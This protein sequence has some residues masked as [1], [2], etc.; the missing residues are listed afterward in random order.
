[1]Y[2]EHF[3]FRPAAILPVNKKC[4][5]VTRWCPV[6]FALRPN[7]ADPIIQ[8]PYRM[9]IATATERDVTLYDTQQP[10][11]FSYFQNI[12]YTRI[13]DLAWSHDGRLLI[14]S[15]TDGYCTLITFEI[16]ELGTA[17]VKEESE[18]EEST[19][20]A[21]AHEEGDACKEENKKKVVVKPSFLHQWA[22]KI[23]VGA[24]NRSKS[25][26][27]SMNNVEKNDVIDITS[28][29]EKKVSPAEA[30]CVA[31]P[32]PKTMLKRI[33]PKKV[34]AEKNDGTPK[35]MGARKESK[36]A[37]ANRLLN[38]LKPPP[39][40]AEATVDVVLEGT[41][42]RDAWKC[43]KEVEAM[44]IDDSDEV[45]G[46]IPDFTLRLEDSTAT[47]DKK[48]LSANDR[49]LPGVTTASNDDIN[50]ETNT[51]VRNS[52]ENIT[53]ENAEQK[54]GVLE[55]KSSVLKEK[56]AEVAG[57]E[58]K[59]KTLEA[60]AVKAPRRVPLIT[61]SSPKVKKQKV[62]NT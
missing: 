31:T 28:S 62:N 25:G 61:L 44:E 14:A 6:L 60:V 27:S 30:E 13:T 29:P 49:S 18:C 21:S 48:R 11:P 20:E 51:Q 1:M 10:R 45:T 24:E 59:T 12:H 54:T 19:T 35:Q 2:V 46:D 4:S 8:L 33:T 41:E 37:E 58:D 34:F 43:D 38:F 53:K 36:R 16:G 40:K 56:S 3:R 23:K 42:A 26:E 57:N 9:I 32:S 17:Y 7:G 22:S 39:K 15:S 55:S 50:S 5:S 47:S 52:V